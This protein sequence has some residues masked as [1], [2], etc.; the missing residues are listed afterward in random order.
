ML[1]RQ[2]NESCLKSC[3]KC[4]EKSSGSSKSPTPRGLRQERPSQLRQAACMIWQQCG[5]PLLFPAVVYYFNQHPPVPPPL[6]GF[7]VKL[8]PTSWR[9][10]C[11]SCS[12]VS[13]ALSPAWAL[14]HRGA[15]PGKA[16]G[17]D[18]QKQYKTPKRMG[19]GKRLWFCKNKLSKI[20]KMT[21]K[22]FSG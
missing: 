7:E 14:C 20:V 10:P 3:S 22:H 5:N 21:G 6:T 17:G 19:R 16:K 9:P 4:P 2:Q 8:T 1:S 15:H 11:P 13:L 12:T 18:V